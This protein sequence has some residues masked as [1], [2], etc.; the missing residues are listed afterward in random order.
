MAEA[1]KKFHGVTRYYVESVNKDRHTE[2]VFAR[3]LELYNSPQKRKAEHGKFKD[4]WEVTMEQ[5][6]DLRA[7]RLS[8]GLKFNEWTTYDNGVLRRPR[9]EKKKKTNLRLVPY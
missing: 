7:N 9:E 2:N 8:M 5:L 3:D 4:V 6:E 1:Q